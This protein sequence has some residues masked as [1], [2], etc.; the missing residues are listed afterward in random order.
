MWRAVV[1]ALLVAGCGPSKAATKSEEPVAE[2]GACPATFSEARTGD[3]LCDAEGDVCEWPEGTCTCG[4]PTRCQS[5]VTADLG[6]HGD[7]SRE[8]VPV[9]W[10]CEWAPGQ[11]D[12]GCPDER[13]SGACD[14]PD[15]QCTYND[16][17][18]CFETLTCVDGA[19]ATTA[20]GLECTMVPSW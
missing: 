4:F 20:G 17:E 3:G 15:Q 8:R 14:Q 1:L 9:S 11:R 13:P 5:K 12:D 7:N 6:V 19:W 10:R 18:C 16:N 2:A